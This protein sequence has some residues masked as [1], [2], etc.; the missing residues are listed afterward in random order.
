MKIMLCGPAGVG[1]TT[2][3]KFIAEHL[4]IPFIEGSAK[5]I[6]SQYKNHSE[7]LNA[8]LVNPKLAMEINTEILNRRSTLRLE[9]PDFVTDRSTIDCLAYGTFE[10]AHQTP[11]GD[12][13]EFINRCVHGVLDIDWLIHVGIS[14][15]QPEIEDNNIRTP[16]Y[17]FNNLIDLLIKDGYQKYGHIIKAVNPKL[18]FQKINF[19]DLETRK[20]FLLEM[21]QTD[22][23]TYSKPFQK[24]LKKKIAE[25]KKTLGEGFKGRKND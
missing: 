5:E 21:L 7:Y 25:D 23:I 14:H 3:A 4:E 8:V 24:N 16:H 15:D 20:Q 1:K 22:G 10:M 18:R 2:L 13:G 19:W 6:T 12:M 11:D 17:A 9:Y